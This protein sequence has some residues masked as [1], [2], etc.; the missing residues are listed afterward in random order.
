MTFNRVCRDCNSTLGESVD[1]HLTN[2]P[3]IV[4][5][6][7][8]LGLAGNSGKIPDPFKALFGEGTLRGSAKRRVRA[9]SAPDG[10]MIAHLLHHV[11]EFIGEDGLRYRNTSIDMRD[12][13][14]LHTIITR[15]RARDGAPPL[16]EA[17]MATAVT[18]ILADREIIAEPT[19]EGAAEIDFK[20]Y[21][22]GVLKIAYELAFRWV[23]ERFLDSEPARQLRDLIAGKTEYELDDPKRVVRFGLNQLLR[24]WPDDDHLA[25]CMRASGRLVIVIRIFRTISAVVDLGDTELLDGPRFLRMEPQRGRFTDAPLGP[26]LF[27]RDRA[28][29]RA[30][31]DRCSSLRRVIM[32]PRVAL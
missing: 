27:R 26:E 32:P 10:T 30:A 28:N 25:L 21:R 4:V 24:L 17:E 3:L 20:M 2:H 9:Y 7:A 11:Q 23:G 31:L 19:V 15:Q 1:T 12:A 22:F 18:G 16:N 5:Q 14:Q 8:M 29:L 6:R 13:K